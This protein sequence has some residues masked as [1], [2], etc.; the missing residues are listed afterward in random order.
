[1]LEGV[2]Q[3]VVQSLFGDVSTKLKTQSRRIF[4][5]ILFTFVLAL[6]GTLTAVYLFLNQDSSSPEMYHSYSHAPR[7]VVY[8]SPPVGAPVSYF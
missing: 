7:N 6:I 2:Q 1:M 4:Y 3:W 5:A 8:T